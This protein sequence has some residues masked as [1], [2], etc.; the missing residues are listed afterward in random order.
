MPL[1]DSSESGLFR[2]DSLSWIMAG[3]IVYVVANVVAYSRRYL[4]GD[5]NFRRHR[6]EVLLLGASVL[7]MVFADQSPRLARGLDDQ[8]PPL[9]KAD[10]P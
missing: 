7:V 1:F 2:A 9:G 10:D 6:G 8:Q 5:R 3:L 4:A